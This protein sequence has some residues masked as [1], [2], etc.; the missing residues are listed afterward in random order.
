MKEAW[1]SFFF[2]FSRD[3]VICGDELVCEGGTVTYEGC[4]ML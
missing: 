2:F 1:K 4:A 3:V